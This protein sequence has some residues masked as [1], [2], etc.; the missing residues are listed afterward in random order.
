VP[1]AEEPSAE[2]W[3]IANTPCSTATEP[4]KVLA[5]ARVNTPD[6]TLTKEASAPEKPVAKVTPE[7]A[8]S[9]ETR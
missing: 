9:T 6:P 8:T 5:A 3:V 7:L 2:G 1:D 4:V